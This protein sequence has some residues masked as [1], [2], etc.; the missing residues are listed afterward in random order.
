MLITILKI[1]ILTLD[2]ILQE[3]YNIEINCCVCLNDHSL[4][5]NIVFQLGL[6]VINDI[7][8]LVF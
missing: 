3:V 4:N 5:I 1:F 8:N 7:C 2:L 6:A